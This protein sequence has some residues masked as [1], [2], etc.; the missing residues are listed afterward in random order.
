LI[1]PSGKC[2]VHHYQETARQ[3]IADFK[4]Q[5]A[6][7]SIVDNIYRYFQNKSTDINEIRS[8]LFTAILFTSAI[9]CTILTVAGVK[10]FFLPVYYLPVTL[11]MICWILLHIPLFIFR[12]SSNA[13]LMRN[14]YCYS[15]FTLI[16]CVSYYSSFSPLTRQ[17]LQLPQIYTLLVL[18]LLLLPL[19]QFIT[20]SFITSILS[21]T[22]VISCQ[23]LLNDLSGINSIVIIIAQIG[24]VWFLSV[25]VAIILQF[26]YRK[27]LTAQEE[28]TGTNNR[29]EEEIAAAVDQIKEQQEQLHQAQKLEAL[30]QMASSIAHDVNNYLTA[31]L[32]FG[33]QAFKKC[34]TESPLRRPLNQIMKAGEKIAALTNKL[35]LFSRKQ[36]PPVGVIAMKETISELKPIIRHLIGKKCTLEVSPPASSDYIKAD[37][38]M[39]EQIIIN[40]AAN[41]RDAMPDGGEISIV[42]DRWSVSPE[43][44]GKNPRMKPGDYIRFF[45]TDRGT[46]IPEDIRTKIFEPFF[47]TKGTGKGTGLGLAVV[48]GIV[49]ELSGWIDVTTTVPG[50]TTFTVYLPAV[51][52]PEKQA[53]KTIF[54]S[55]PEAQEEPSDKR[56]FEITAGESAHRILVIDDQLNLA[57]LAAETLEEHGYE[58]TVVASAEKAYELINNEPGRYDFLF[59]DI[60]LEG[61]RG[62]ELAA[63]IIHEFPS[64]GIILTSGNIAE[65]EALEE[66]PTKEI[67]FLKKPYS[68]ES[69]I[70]AF[71]AMTTS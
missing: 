5:I 1:S 13:P 40:F 23:H 22:L 66:L 53:D 65:K 8:V 47:T 50:G 46:G 37:V 52:P 42:F 15:G 60:V 30:G 35:L 27:M 51:P 33:K 48:Y 20:F 19:I 3:P 44:C 2:T 55:S 12:K 62:T 4:Q 6:A 38:V 41:A 70:A 56:A 18:A 16:V 25:A 69:L 64:I 24:G 71:D 32:G 28:L 31:I 68:E 39:L 7:M 57:E 58:C 29:L 59:T 43:A 36:P 14:I 10:I 67:L 17:L 63:K 26:Y 21:M 49:K 11:I 61:M 54:T 9:A 45:F 34:E